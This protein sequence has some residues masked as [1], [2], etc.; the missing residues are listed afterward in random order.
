MEGQGLEGMLGRRQE[1]GWKCGF[2][3]LE[4]WLEWPEAG[5]EN[6]LDGCLVVVHVVGGSV[7]VL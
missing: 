6:M 4:D 3:W 2:L 1:C 5:R 7:V